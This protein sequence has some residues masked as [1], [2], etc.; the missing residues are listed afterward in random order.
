MSLSLKQ[1]LTVTHRQY[2]GEHV[3]KRRLSGSVWADNAV[4]HKRSNLEIDL[5]G[6]DE[7]TEILRKLPRFEQR[8][9]RINC[10]GCAFVRLLLCE[11][12]ADCVVGQAS[13]AGDASSVVPAH[14]FLQ[15]TAT[16][17][18]ISTGANISY[19][20]SVSADSLFSRMIN[21][22][23]PQ[24]G[25]RKW[26]TPQDRH[27]QAVTCMLPTQIIGIDT[28]EHDGRKSTSVADN[29]GHE[30]EGAET[31]K[32]DVIAQTARTLLIVSHGLKYAPKRRMRQSPS[33][34]Q[35]HMTITTVTT[36]KTWNEV[37]LAKLARGMP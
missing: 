26:W 19:Q 2:A 14:V 17:I 36:T 31:D 16:R 28:L 37:S 21:A 34:S 5:P 15:A 35:A 11:V 12:E 33:P 18:S 32:V 7:A 22:M 29:R 25:P 4:E 1:Y 9:G 24:S 13:N 3:I 27:Q 23:A 20:F 6:C 10:Q 30:C 8:P